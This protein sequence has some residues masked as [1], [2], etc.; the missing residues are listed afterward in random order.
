MVD[1]AERERRWQEG[2]AAL[3][4]LAASGAI[5]PDEWERERVPDRMLPGREE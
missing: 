3:E 4:R 2:V 5:D 1:E